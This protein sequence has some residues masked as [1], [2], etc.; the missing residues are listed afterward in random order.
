MADQN[1]M[2]SI[3][4]NKLLSLF[5]SVE[6]TAD[7]NNEDKE[8]TAEDFFDTV[9]SRVQKSEETDVKSTQVNVKD[10]DTEIQENKAVVPELTHEAGI[11][12]RYDNT[13]EIKESTDTFKPVDEIVNEDIL[14]VPEDMNITQYKGGT[15]Q[16]RAEED[17][18]I[19]PCLLLRT[20]DLPIYKATALQTL[21]MKG[22]FD[23][24]AVVYACYIEY[25]ENMLHLGYIDNKA[26]RALLKCNIFD[27][28]EKEV[29]LS[30][31]QVIRGKYIQA[32]CSV[33]TG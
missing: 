28:F 32:L 6:G 22:T 21:L 15:V 31:K 9:M 13:L 23:S 4:Q 3:S 17:A 16:L 27:T 14:I 24:D 18:I 25:Q 29:K 26:L 1:N 12:A 2:Q 11:T 5:L 19:Y 30:E 10:T 33:E 7:L 20:D 8:E